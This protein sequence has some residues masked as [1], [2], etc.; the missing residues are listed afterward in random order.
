MSALIYLTGTRIK[1]SLKETLHRPSKLILYLFLLAMVVLVVVSGSVD[2][3]ESAQLRDIREF[4]AMVLGL[5]YLMFFLGAYQGFRSGASFYSMADVNLLFQTPLSPKGILIYGLVRQMGVTLL[6]GCFLVFQYGWLHTLYGISLG[7]LLLVLLC[8]ALTLFCSQITAMALYSYLS[9]H[10]QRRTPF[11]AGFVLLLI[12]LALYFTL[13][14]AMDPGNVLQALVDRCQARAT[15]FLPVGGWLLALEQGIFTG[16]WTMALGGAGGILLLW[17]LIFLWISRTSTDYY[18]DVL[19]ATEISFSA[20]N[21]SKEGKVAEALPQKVRLGKVG[22]GHGRGASVF[23]FKHQVENRRSR[24]L[25][26]DTTSLIFAAVSILVSLFMREAGILPIFCFVIYLQLFSVSSGRWA[27]EL[28][29]P[30]VYLSPQPPFVK[31]VMTCLESMEK[32]LIQGIC[33]FVPIGLILGAS[34]WETAACVAAHFG[35]SLLFMAA[36]ILMDRLFG[37][38]QSKGLILVLYLLAILLL[39]LPGIILAVWVYFLLAATAWATVL[40]LLATLGWNLLVGALITLLCRNILNLA[41]LN[42]R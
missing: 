6:T 21:S 23:F 37:T 32:F 19:Q 27:R 25:L 24:L 10:P 31:L 39:S 17:G 5:V 9:T 20:I 22:L 7:D 2:P 40:A 18:E 33:T 15:Y 30:Y 38:L 13:P 11:K 12:L 1:N 14:M 34:P 4:H 41:E 42:T 29:L 35:F 28:L 26:L 8:Y 36:N 3:V 16:Q